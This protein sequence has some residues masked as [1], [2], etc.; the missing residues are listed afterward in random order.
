MGISHLS[1]LPSCAPRQNSRCGLRHAD[2]LKRGSVTGGVHLC[3]KVST[4][5]ASPYGLWRPICGGEL[6]K[7]LDSQGRISSI[8]FKLY[9]FVCI[10][11]FVSVRS[12]AYPYVYMCRGHQTTCRSWLSSTLWVFKDRTLE[13]GVC[14]LR[15]GYSLTCLDICPQYYPAH[16]GKGFGSSPYSFVASG[17]M[18]SLAIVQ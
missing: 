4:D 8:I 10:C 2:W 12:C 3:L 14:L 18:F 6:R 16:E 15:D 11:V 17:K 9:I 7:Q 5:C 13:A 1:Y